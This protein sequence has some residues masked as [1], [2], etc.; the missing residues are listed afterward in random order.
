MF[1]FTLRS[2]LYYRRS[3]VVVMLAVAVATAVIGGSPD[4]WRFCACQFAA[5]DNE[6]P[7][8]NHSGSQFASFFS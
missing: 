8:W 5:D 3:H 2:I 6:P 7:G 4:R 1:R